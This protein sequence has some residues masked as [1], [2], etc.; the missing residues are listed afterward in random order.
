MSESKFFCSYRQSIVPTLILSEHYKIQNKDP[1]VTSLDEFESRLKSHSTPSSQVRAPDPPKISRVQQEEDPEE[2][3][4]A[5]GREMDED[6]D[7]DEHFDDD[8]DQ[9]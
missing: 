8:L 4:A 6:D 7:D 1:K 5:V 3:K 2:A 9:D